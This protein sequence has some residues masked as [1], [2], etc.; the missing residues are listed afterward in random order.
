MIR[1]EYG[2]PIRYIHLEITEQGALG[3]G[4][5]E[6]INSLHRLG[7]TMILD[8]FGT[9]YANSSRVKSIALSGI[10][11]DMSLVWA[12]F[13]K[14]DPY[15]PNLIKGLRDL[16]FTITAEGVETEEMVKGLRAMGCNYFQ[17]YYYSRPV[18]MYEFLKKYR[19]S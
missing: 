14:P 2:I 3:P 19:V 16:G 13:K 4:G 11:I 6:Q 8:D 17:G 5:L 1:K 12:H 18:P 10:K 15:L 7:Y 9:G